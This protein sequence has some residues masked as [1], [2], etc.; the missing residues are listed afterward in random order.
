[1][2]V[3][4]KLTCLIVASDSQRARSFGGARV[5]FGGA[6]VPARERDLD[7]VQR[8]AHSERAVC[9]AVVRAVF[10]ETHGALGLLAV[11]LVLQHAARTD[12]SPH[13]DRDP[14][15]I[16]KAVRPRVGNRTRA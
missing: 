6:R 15:Q 12:A 2:A 7:S 14:A 11:R 9:A 3:P 4:A 13:I 8:V 5:W 16:L 10:G 1:M